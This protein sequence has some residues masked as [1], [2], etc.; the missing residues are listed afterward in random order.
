LRIVVED[1]AAG[2]A[3]V[4]VAGKEIRLPKALTADNVN[5]I[6]DLPVNPRDLSANVPV[7]FR[8]LAGNHAGYRVDMTSIVLEH[9]P[10]GRAMQR[11]AGTVAPVGRDGWRE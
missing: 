11:T 1:I 2:E 5:R 3:A 4:T 7:T 9:P 6:L 8:T 10:L